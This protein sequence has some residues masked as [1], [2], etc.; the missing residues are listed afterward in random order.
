MNIIYK[1][2]HCRNNT[3]MKRSSTATL[4]LWNPFMNQPSSYVSQSTYQSV[5]L[6]I[7]EL[8]E[9]FISTLLALLTT[10]VDLW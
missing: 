10:I 5:F 1:H 2:T 4:S 9:K 7:L 8:G 3:L 6:V